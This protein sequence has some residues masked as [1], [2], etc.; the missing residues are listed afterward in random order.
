MRAC[1]VYMQIENLSICC[2]ISCVE[3]DGKMKLV[4]E[5]VQKRKRILSNAHD[6]GH[7]GINRMLD[8]VSKYYWPGISRDVKEYV[9]MVQIS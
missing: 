5:D 8:L 2:N 4:V 1:K 7:F 3:T 9:S 6:T